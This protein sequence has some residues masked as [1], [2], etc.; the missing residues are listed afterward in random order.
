MELPDA[1]A[2][3]AKNS[4]SHRGHGG[5]RRNAGRKS[6][7]HI[8][9]ETVIDYDEARARNESIKADLNTLE[10]KI[11]S[12]EYVARNGVRQASAT[13][14]ASLAQTLR[15]VPDNLERKLGITPEVAEEVGRQIDAALQDL[16]NEFEIMCGDDE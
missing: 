13:A 8:K 12:S 14:L 1:P 15:S 10:F 3:H 11:K 6:D 5:S 2:H 16:A 4:S 7:T 9:P